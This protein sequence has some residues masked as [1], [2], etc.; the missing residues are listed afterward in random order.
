MLKRNL[1]CFLLAR[2]KIWELQISHPI[3]RFL[4]SSILFDVSIFINYQT[5]NWEKKTSLK[6]SVDVNV[7]IQFIF[8]QTKPSQTHRCQDL[9]LKENQK[10]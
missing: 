3:T 9:A 5:K 8:T 1:L 2:E 7:E 4:P 10:H 6:L